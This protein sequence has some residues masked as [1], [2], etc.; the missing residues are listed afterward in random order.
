MNHERILHLLDSEAKRLDRLHEIEE[1]R[2]ADWLTFAT[3]SYEING[4][5]RSINIIKKE[6][7]KEC[8]N[9]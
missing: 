5:F 7:E 2:G 3:I 9:V 1:E 8:R 4:I 6:L